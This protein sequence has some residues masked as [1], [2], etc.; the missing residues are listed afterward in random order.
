V[1]KSLAGCLELSQQ[2]SGGIETGTGEAIEECRRA[3][4]ASSDK[5]VEGVEND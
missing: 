2:G 4:W 5:G 3:P 1:V